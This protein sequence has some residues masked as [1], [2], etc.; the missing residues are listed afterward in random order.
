MESSIQ[1]QPVQTPL[2]SVG[3]RKRRFGTAALLGIALIGGAAGGAAGNALSAQWLSPQTARAATTQT[4]AQ[5]VTGS[6][7]GAVLQSVG[8]SVV[9]ITSSGAAGYGR[10]V[11][12]GTGSGVVVD[13][14]GLILTNQH[15]VAGA[16]SVSVEFST[17]EQL[18]ATVLGTDSGSDLA[19][20]RVSGMPATVPAATL[21]DSDTVAAGDTAI[22]IGSP[23]GLEQTVTQ[24]IIS[25]V[26]RSWSGGGSLQSDL[27]QTD[28][29]INPGNSGGPLLNAAGEVIGINTMIE[30]PVEGNVGIGFA[31]P[32]NVAKAQLAELQAGAQLEQGFLGISVAEATGAGTSGVTVADVAAGSGAEAAG[33]VA[34]DVITAVDGAAVAGY[35]ALVDAIDGKQPG[36]TVRVAVER[37]GQQEEVTV[38]LGA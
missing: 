8:P 36:E 23:F 25:A 31:V 12:Q 11:Q 27:I 5:T 24:G 13:D 6:T 20:L 18:A 28:T 21:G 4:I 38:T 35:D 33:L 29:P 19:L 9:E 1:P 2:A 34:G 26:D 3:G 30:S 15:V 17:G 7:A 10:Q 37:D 14:S 22:A 32:I 16:S